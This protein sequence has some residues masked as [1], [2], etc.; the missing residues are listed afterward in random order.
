LGHRSRIIHL[1]GHPYNVLTEAQVSL[2]HRSALRILEQVGL[3]IQNEDLL[4]VMAD[5]GL[6]VDFDAELVRFPSAV[7]ERFIAEADKYDW[8]NHRPQVTSSAGVYHSRFHDPAT[9]ELID[10]DEQ[11]LAF[12][13][14]L[15][16]RLDHL[17][18]AS[19]L[20][21]PLPVPGPLVSLYER[22][23]SWKLGARE[24]GS[25][26][27]DE[28]CPYLL[29][30]YEILAGSRGA[31]VE[32][33]FHATVHMSPALRLGRGQAYQV[34]Y[35]RKRGLRVWIGTMFAMGAAAP[36]TLSGAVTLNLAEQL[37][38]RIVNCALFGDKYLFLNCALAPM[39]M[40]T[41]VHTFGRPEM[42]AANMMTAQLARHY[43]ASFRGQAG[44][45]D[46]KFPSVEVG[47]QKAMTAMAT[48]LAGGHAGVDA[49]LLANDEICSPVQ[50]ILDNE[51]VS[52]LK[53]FTR[54][55]EVD[56]EAIGLETIFEAGPAGLYADKPHTARHYRSELW[57]PSIWARQPLT[58]WRDGGAK[59]DVDRARDIALEVQHEPP[60]PPGIS[61][62]LQRDI[63]AL[64]KRAEAKLV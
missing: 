58:P 4:K 19:M 60:D 31:K 16:R 5:Y 3:D 34:A 13:I 47:A 11:R 17:R 55:F 35:F 50:M 27:Q 1:A 64:I 22:Y 25:L 53:H 46:G 24:G 63:L 54:E 49:G 32:D 43:G 18:G 15:A 52:A 42:A 61:Q 36:V 29:E 44:L 56:E 59:L 9:G 40:R 30:L 6:A 20:G 8:A 48:L 14:R 39:D 2:I 51:M 33:V 23:Y 7:V 12:Y 10:W 62:K 41:M 45:T 38:L 26:C 28:I 37:A 57:E 21:C